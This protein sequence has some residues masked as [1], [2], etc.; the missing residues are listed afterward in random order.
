[1]I[2]PRIQ[3][4]SVAIP[5]NLAGILEEEI[6]FGNLKPH[7]RLTEED[8]ALKYGVSRS[9]VREA[10]RMLERDGLVLREARR[11]IWVSPLSLRDFDE[12]YVCRIELEG[13]AAE[14]AA[15]SADAEKKAELHVVLDEMRDAQ[16]RGNAREFF[17]FDVRG[18][19]LTYELAGN[20]TLTR[21]LGGL[22]KQA[23]RYRFHAYQQNPRIIA[24]SLDDTARIFDAV[25][26]GNARAAKELTENLIRQI[27]QDMRLAIG[28][29]FGEG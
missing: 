9:P 29:F 7:D 20:R 23:L 25:M 12:V 10:L 1:M 14:Q 19:L 3:N 6:I 13:L 21:L 4:L 27:W 24:L 8:V 16:Q 11:G 2:L 15:K 26:A 22:E 28:Q 18:S 17:L 5:E